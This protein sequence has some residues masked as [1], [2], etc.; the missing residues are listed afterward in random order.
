MTEK[1]KLIIT[2]TNLDKSEIYYKQL[3]NR[4]IIIYTLKK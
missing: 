3:N 4:Q 1:I 2:T